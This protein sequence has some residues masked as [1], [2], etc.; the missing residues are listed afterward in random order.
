MTKKTSI[1][2]YKIAVYT[3]MIHESNE[4]TGEECGRIIIRR[5]IFQGWPQCQ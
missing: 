3:V 2:F 5:I 4:D 1:K